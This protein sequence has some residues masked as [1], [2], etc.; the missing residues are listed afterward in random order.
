LAREQDHRL[1]L[2]DFGPFVIFTALYA[3]GTLGLPEIHLF[4][5]QVKIGEIPS[6]FVAIF[7]YPAV[8]GLT[9]GQF[10][11]NLGVEASPI[12]MLSPVVSFVGLLII[13]RLRKASV[14]AGC[15]AYIILTSV[16]LMYLLPLTSGVSISAATPSVLL[17]QT[18]AVLIGYGGY[19]AANRIRASAASSADST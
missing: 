11:A 1:K 18:I 17:G 5:Y 15:I 6:A 16:W 7:G 2:E 3:A 10:I 19:V 14:L 9:L 12:V 13:Y 8:L 4:A